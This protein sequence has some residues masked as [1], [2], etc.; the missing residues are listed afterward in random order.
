MKRKISLLLAALAFFGVPLWAYLRASADVEM[1]RD[2]HGFVCGMPILAIYFLALV[3]SSLL[4]VA[5]LCFG[6]PSYRA[7]SVPR[8]KA[9]ML[10]LAVLALPLLVTVAAG[11]GIWVFAAGA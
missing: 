4:S 11:I 5:A 9:R 8:S 6:V 7:L 10:E 3:G 1:Q 2:V